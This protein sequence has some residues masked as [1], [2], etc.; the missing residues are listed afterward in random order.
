MAVNRKLEKQDFERTK[1]LTK[2]RILARRRQ[3][4]KQLFWH[5]AVCSAL[6]IIFLCVAS[7]A[8][9]MFSTM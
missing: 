8:L 6:V 4:R 2:I 9:H 7:V 5:V 3:R 1:E